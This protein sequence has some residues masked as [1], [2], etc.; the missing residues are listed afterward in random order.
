MF[1]CFFEAIFEMFLDNHSTFEVL[2]MI[3]LS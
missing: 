1:C 2:L 3:Y